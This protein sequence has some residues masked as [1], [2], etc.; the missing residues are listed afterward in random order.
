MPRYCIRDCDNDVG[1]PRNHVFGEF[2]ITFGASFSGIPI[3]NQI[4]LLDVAKFTKLQKERS[5]SFHAAVL[6]KIRNWS[7][8][9]N[10]SNAVE[11]AS[12]LRARHQRPHRRAAQPRNERAPS[13]SMTSSA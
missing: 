11:L 7:N 6:G 13:H 3:Y 2:A 4:L 9:S 8:W 1:L 5:K 12:L 10:P